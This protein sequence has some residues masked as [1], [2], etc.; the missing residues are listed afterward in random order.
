MPTR[1]SS[2]IWNWTDEFWA[3]LETEFAGTQDLKTLKRLQVV[4]AARVSDGQLEVLRQLLSGVS[5]GHSPLR[6]AAIH[7]HLLP[8]SLQEEVKPFESMTNLAFVRKFLRNQHVSIVLHGHKHTE[9]TYVDQIPGPGIDAEPSSSVRVISGA[10]A[11]GADVDKSDVFRL[12]DISADSGTVNVQRIPIAIPGGTFSIG[13]P[14]PLHFTQPGG[15]T[16][17]RNSRHPRD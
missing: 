8:V 2:S 7:H 12:L 9:F 17:H 15:P 6:I 13:Q 10:A 11:T 14:E 5:D 16:G 4:D 3:R 1:K